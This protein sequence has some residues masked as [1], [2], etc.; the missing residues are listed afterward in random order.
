MRLAGNKKNPRRPLRGPISRY[1][2]VSLIGPVFL[3][4][5]GRHNLLKNVSPV[6]FA[7]HPFGWFALSKGKRTTMCLVS[8][9]TSLREIT[10][11]FAT[12]P[13]HLLWGRIESPILR[14]H[15]HLCPPSVFL[16][17]VYSHTRQRARKISLSRVKS[18][19]C[20]FM[21]M[22]CEG[23]HLCRAGAGFPFPN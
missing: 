13:T 8:L 15:G 4:Q 14:L 7:S 10:M 6:G 1:F 18:S 2:P 12:S 23:A 21:R 22:P 16:R 19:I 20:T 11:V 9:D 3:W 5:P 17:L